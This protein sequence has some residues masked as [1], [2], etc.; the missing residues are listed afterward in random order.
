MTAKEVNAINLYGFKREGSLS[1]SV[2]AIIGT[3][4]LRIYTGVLN[5]CL[6]L[7]SSILCVVALS[8]NLT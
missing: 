6:I 3:R 7:K 2:N 4:L 1:V 5:V 8:Y